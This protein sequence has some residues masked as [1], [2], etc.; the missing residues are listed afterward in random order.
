MFA[1]TVTYTW[2]Y[3]MVLNLLDNDQG[4]IFYKFPNG[5]KHKVLFAGNDNDSALDWAMLPRDKFFNKYCKGSR[6]DETC[7][8][9]EKYIKEKAIS[10]ERKKKR[11]PLNIRITG[12]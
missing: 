7:L 8:K 11:T 5:N 1:P 6:A 4:V 3:K 12:T 9:A 10:V 2:M